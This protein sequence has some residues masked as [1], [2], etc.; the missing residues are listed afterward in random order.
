MEEYNLELRTKDR[1]TT[2]KGIKT[3]RVPIMGETISIFIEKEKF[4]EWYKKH[5]SSRS[6][7]RNYSEEH[8][9]EEYINLACAVYNMKNYKVEEVEHS[10]NPEHFPNSS[11]LETNLVIIAKQQ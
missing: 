6:K 2:F 5:F 9:T 11:N 8:L 7:E 10:L 3:A 1:N 4:K